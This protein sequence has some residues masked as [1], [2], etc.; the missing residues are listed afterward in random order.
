M[1]RGVKTTETGMQ[2]G[3]GSETGNAGKK[4]RSASEDR[5]R[6]GAGGENGMMERTPSRSVRRR[7]EKR[8]SAG[9]REETRTVES[10]P[11]TQTKLKSRLRITEKKRAKGSA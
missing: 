7:E 3:R 5:M 1:K 4:R 2:T 8:K 11:V 6:T 9:R 10:A